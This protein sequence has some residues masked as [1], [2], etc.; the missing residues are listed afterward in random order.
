[1]ALSGFVE[2][3]K[4]FPLIAGINFA[5]AV[6]EASSY[7]GIAV[8]DRVVG[9]NNPELATTAQPIASLP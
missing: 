3:I 1:M 5:G 7:P 9:F 2:I 8:G 6:V 4:Q